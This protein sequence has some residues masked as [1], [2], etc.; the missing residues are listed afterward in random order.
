ME[1]S[2]EIYFAD[3]DPLLTAVESVKYNPD[4]NKPGR[5]KKQRL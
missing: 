3:P 1:A 2:H 5:K 4:G